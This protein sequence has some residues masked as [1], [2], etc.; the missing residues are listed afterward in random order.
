MPRLMWIGMLLAG[1]LVLAC[2]SDET[3]S[4]TH[5]VSGTTS[6]SNSG[7]SGS[8]GPGGSAGTLE[9]FDAHIH[10][11]P[12]ET[13]AEIVDLASDAGFTGMVVLGPSND[14]G[15]KQH[16]GYAYPFLFVSGDDLET[17]ATLVDQVSVAL[18]SG[19]IYGVGELSI[20]HFA[21]GG[22]DDEVHDP[23]LPNFKA[24]YQVIADEGALLNIHCDSAASMRDFLDAAA[25]ASPTVLWAHIGDDFADNVRPLLEDY[26][27][28]YIDLSCRNPFYENRPLSL[29]DQSLANADGTIKN[30]W[31]ALF[32]DYPTRFM[33]GSDVGPP[34]RVEILISDTVPY[35]RNVL[36]QLQP[37]TAEAIAS[38]NIKTLLGI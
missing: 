5:V 18:K 20:R 32:E 25:E 6:T 11:K 1:T 13:A 29:E 10:V 27:N 21:T 3:P 16:A 14:G 9:L 15:L 33:F 35:F 37:S 23:T 8:T 24:L 34:G 26:D 2:S 36:S 17:D 7:S 19:D 30:D 38:G 12:S 4:E 28:L 31:K 22:D